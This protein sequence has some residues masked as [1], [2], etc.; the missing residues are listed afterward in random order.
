MPDAGRPHQFKAGPTPFAPLM[1]Y[2]S[3]LARLRPEVSL[4]P[5]TATLLDR[6]LT[7]VVVSKDGIAMPQD[8]IRSGRTIVLIA[9]S[10]H[11]GETS[12]KEAAQLVAR[13]LVAGDLQSALD[14][15]IVL[16][17][18]VLNPVVDAELHAY[19]YANIFPRIRQTLCAEDYDGF[20]YSGA[21]AA[22]G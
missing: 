5:L 1:E 6:P 22:G 21:P 8:A 16:F 4:R 9:S 18:P 10:V 15:V 11:G 7:V 14:D 13:D 3:E 12:P 20:D 19:P 2:W 17:V